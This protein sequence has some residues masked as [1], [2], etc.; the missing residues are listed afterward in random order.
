MVLAHGSERALEADEGRIGRSGIVSARSQVS[1]ECSLQ[2]ASSCAFSE[3]QGGERKIIDGL[4]VHD[5]DS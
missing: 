1:D 5:P 3:I 4:P 2:V